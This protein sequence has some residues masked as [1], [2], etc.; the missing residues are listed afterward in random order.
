M[1]RYADRLDEAAEDSSKAKTRPDD[2]E[3]TQDTS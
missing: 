1:D 3:D 2:D